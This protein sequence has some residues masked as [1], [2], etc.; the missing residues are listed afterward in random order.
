MQ[1]VRIHLPNRQ[2]FETIAIPVGKYEKRV[3]A[4]H[5]PGLQLKDQLVEIVQVKRDI[6]VAHDQFGPLPTI[7]LDEAE[8]RWQLYLKLLLVTHVKVK[9]IINW[10]KQRS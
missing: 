6:L 10:R 9:D 8:K 7:V 4:A 3:Y 2:Q 1:A 5:F